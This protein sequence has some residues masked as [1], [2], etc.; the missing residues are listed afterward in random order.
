MPDPFD[1]LI[2]DHARFRAL[3][4]RPEGATRSHSRKKLLT[5]LERELKTHAQ[6]EEEVYYPTFRQAAQSDEDRQLFFCSTEEHHL[7]DMYLPELKANLESLEQFRA[8]LSVT[9]DLLEKHATEE[10][11][12][13]LILRARVLLTAD[14][15][16]DLAALAEER[17]TEIARKWKNPLT[18]PLKKLQ[19]TVQKVT[20][21]ALKNVSGK[22][23]AG[24]KRASS[25][26]QD[27]GIR[28]T[29]H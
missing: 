27:Q 7:L 23:L 15:L 6:L 11:E 29:F 24:S 3:I 20:P 8:K 26:M 25:K 16:R 18:R 1:S 2:E 4:S 17:R 22:A 14:E 28:V 21:S 9:R 10:E 12:G 19:S 13:R 5:E